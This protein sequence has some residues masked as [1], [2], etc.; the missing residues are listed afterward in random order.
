MMTPTQDVNETKLLSILR[1]LFSR[2]M[3][4]HIKIMSRFNREHANACMTPGIVTPLCECI[5][6][7]ATNAADNRKD[8]ANSQGKGTGNNVSAHA[9]STPLPPSETGLGELSVYFRN[10]HKHSA[11]SLN[12]GDKLIQSTWEHIHA[13]IRT[14]RQ[15]DI[16]TARLHVDLA[17]N[18]LKE[19]EH[20]LSAPVFSSFT[21]EVLK[22][23]NQINGHTI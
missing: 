1:M 4:L 6:K 20:Y 19:A 3:T 7:L 13:S 12:A 10:M 23:L 2:I 5:E 15:G 17:N 22:V 9:S 18:A 14:A 11:V 21:Q 16:K 8:G